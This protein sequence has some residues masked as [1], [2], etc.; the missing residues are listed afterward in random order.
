MVIRVSKNLCKS[1]NLCKSVK[2]VAGKFV[3][4]REIRAKF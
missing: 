4:I 2:S 3:L 1:N